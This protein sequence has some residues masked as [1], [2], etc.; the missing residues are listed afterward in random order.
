M[1]EF[2]RVEVN[3]RTWS[4]CWNVDKTAIRERS[5][6]TGSRT[7]IRSIDLEKR[8][9]SEGVYMLD[10][11]LECSAYAESAECE[12]MLDPVF[13]RRLFPRKVWIRIKRRSP[14]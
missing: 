12:S 7:K 4:G 14:S 10:A 9:Q 6:D 1:K 8:A 3:M 5:G 11:D 13:Y 2:Y